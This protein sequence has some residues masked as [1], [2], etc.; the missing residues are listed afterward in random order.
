MLLILVYLV[1]SIWGYVS[2][3]NLLSR[4]LLLLSH[5]VHYLFEEWCLLKAESLDCWKKITKWK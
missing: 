3:I 1:F 2:V 4:N 5:N